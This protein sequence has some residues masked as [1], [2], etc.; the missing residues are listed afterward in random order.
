MILAYP[1]S[2]DDDF[3][4]GYYDEDEEDAVLKAEGTEVELGKGMFVSLG[5]MLH[6]DP[7]IVMFEVTSVDTE[8]LELDELDLIQQEENNRYSDLSHLS[9]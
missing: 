5:K 1:F 6:K 2:S 4:I 7:N 9:F 3:I 8:H